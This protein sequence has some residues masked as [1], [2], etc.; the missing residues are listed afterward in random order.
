MDSTNDGRY[1][2]I[3]DG[4]P[5]DTG[6]PDGDGVQGE[7]WFNGYDDDGDGLI[8]EDYFEN[9][10]KDDG[11]II[12]CTEDT[13]EDGCI[14]CEGDYGVD[15]NIDSGF[16]VWTDGYDNDGNGDIDDGREMFTNNSGTNYDPEWA[17]N[18]DEKNIIVKGGRGVENVHGEPNLWYVEGATLIF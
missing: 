4:D 15:E 18:L 12:I 3:G 2:M 5:N 9:N 16:D 7:D 10:G 11:G 1:V 8:D 17:Y 13:K 6:D 14:C